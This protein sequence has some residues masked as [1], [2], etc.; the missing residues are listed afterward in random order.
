MI[1]RRHDADGDAEDNHS[2]Q[3]PAMAPKNQLRALS[4]A[5]ARMRCAGNK[6]AD[7]YSTSH[8][9]AGRCRRKMPRDILIEPGA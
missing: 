6:T 8:L 3:H 2:Q 5:F 1:I 4:A 7:A 9:S